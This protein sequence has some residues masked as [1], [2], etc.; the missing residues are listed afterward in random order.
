M[1]WA[2]PSDKKMRGNF[3]ARGGVSIYHIRTENQV[4]FPEV[5]NSPQVQGVRWLQKFA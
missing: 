4:A 3:A 5:G 2:K 1:A